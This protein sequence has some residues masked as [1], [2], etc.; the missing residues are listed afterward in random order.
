MCNHITSVKS[1]GNVIWRVYSSVII[2]FETFTNTISAG[3]RSDV[4]LGATSRLLQGQK[5]DAPSLCALGR[6]GLEE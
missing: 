2:L 1:F 6:Q 5:I 4:Y 3:T